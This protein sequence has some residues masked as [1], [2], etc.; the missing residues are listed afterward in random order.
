MMVDIDLAPEL[1]E[2]RPEIQQIL[3]AIDEAFP[4]LQSE[5]EA[6][7]RLRRPTPAVQNALK[8]T[9]IFKLSVPTSLGGFEATPLELL[10]V[11]EK[12]SHADASLGWLARVL[13]GETGVAAT[14]LSREN[15]EKL[16]NGADWPR[17]AGQSTSFHGTA[18]KVDGGY[19]VTGSWPF[20]AG[21]SMATHVNMGVTVE[22]T[23]E[24]I[25]CLVPRSELFMSDNWD[26]LGLL[27]TSSLDYEAK[28]LFV[29]EK[30]AYTVEGS[31]G[32]RRGMTGKLSPTLVDSLKQAAWSQGVGRRMLDELKQLASAAANREHYSRG[33]SAVSSDEFFYEFARHYSHVRGTLALLTETWSGYEQTLKA[34]EE[35]TQQQETM[36]RLATNLATRTAL[37]ISQIA[38]RFAGFQVMRHS[39]LQRFFRDSHAGTQHRGSRLAVTAECGRMLA[40]V[41]P[42]GSTWG[43]YELE[44]P[45]R[46]STNH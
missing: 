24:K 42:E 12:I 31:D 7:E 28:D 14:F 41:V 11:I 10:R 30:F 2:L 46:T 1:P 13:T 45:G 34:D 32:G 27:A 20:M 26:M 44:I 39:A 22:G 37:E 25:V 5:A 29:P 9:G 17:V 18:V 40:G 38:H 4:L 33:D 36:A 8:E 21:T 3:D 35:P 15:A 23:G 43:F 16:F 6:G 19:Q